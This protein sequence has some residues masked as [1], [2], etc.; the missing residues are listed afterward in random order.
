MYNYNQHIYQY[1]M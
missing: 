1:N